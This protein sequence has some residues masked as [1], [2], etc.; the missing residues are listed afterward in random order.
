MC[1]WYQLKID[2]QSVNQ[3]TNQTANWLR[4]KSPDEMDKST[5]N[6]WLRKTNKS[7]LAKVI[8]ANATNEFSTES[9]WYISH[10]IALIRTLCYIPETFEDLTF[11]V[12][13]VTVIKEIQSK[14]VKGEKEDQ[15][16]RY[17]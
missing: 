11:R 17:Y 5:I 16:G 7:E 9:T 14:V 15:L 6:F 1:T 8:L 13:T 12:L 4:P 3:S 2:C 10:L